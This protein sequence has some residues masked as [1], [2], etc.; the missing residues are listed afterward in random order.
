M[1]SVEDGPS[2]QSYWTTGLM[3]IIIFGT[4]LVINTMAF[5]HRRKYSAFFL[6]FFSCVSMVCI[7]ELPRYVM[8]L[9]HRRYTSQWA[10]AI[11]ITASYLFCLCL[12]MIV[13]LWSTFVEL[14]PIETKIYSKVA[15]VVFNV[16]FLALVL[17]SVV[18]CV[19][20][21]SL[22]G[23]FKSVTFSAFIITELLVYFMYTVC[24]GFLSVKLVRR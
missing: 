19:T 15:L 8:L 21:E 1:G 16:L 4:I 12:T 14:G 13:Q 5:R 3:G 24:L 2:Q 6:S 7:L 17:T 9:V 23:F 18:F 22:D 20:A 11:H 10:Y